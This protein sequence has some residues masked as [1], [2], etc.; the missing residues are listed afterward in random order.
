MAPKLGQEY[1]RSLRADGLSE[2]TIREHLKAMGYNAGR[3]TQLLAATAASGSRDVPAAMD[4]EAGGHV[5]EVGFACAY[6]PVR[7]NACTMISNKP[8]V[9]DVPWCLTGRLEER[10]CR[11]RGW[12]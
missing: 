10:R 11:S 8:F 4:A 2:A 12:V 7:G 5:P 3:I 9:L 6:K 1:V